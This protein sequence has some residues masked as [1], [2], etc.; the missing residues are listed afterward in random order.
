MYKTGLFYM[1]RKLQFR[2]LIVLSFIEVPNSE[3][4][5]AAMYQTI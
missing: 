4:K 3:W 1:N 5:K 2:F